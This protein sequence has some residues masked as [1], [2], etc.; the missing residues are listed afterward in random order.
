MSPVFEQAVARLKADRADLQVAVVAAGTVATEV[1]AR[2][3]AWPFRVQLVQEAEKY[4]AM[5]ACDVALAT[6]GT[7]STELAL[8]GAPM[9]IAYRFDGLSYAIMRP[10]FTGK[11]ATLFNIAAD[12]EI[13]P[14]LIQNDATPE[15]MAAEVGAAA[16]RSRRPGGPGGAADGGPGSDGQARARTRRSWRPGRY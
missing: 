16:G 1:A 7:V 3:A 9:V 11:Y 8:A 12:E 15:R 5:R 4:D 13:A 10:F 6:S 2:I 14:E